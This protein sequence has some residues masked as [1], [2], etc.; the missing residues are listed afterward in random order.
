M[1]FSAFSAFAFSIPCLAAGVAASIGG[2]GY[3]TSRVGPDNADCERVTYNLSIE[4][5]NTIFDES[6]TSNINQTVLT[7]GLQDYVIG[8]IATSS[9]SNFSALYEVG[10]GKEKST[11][12]NT[13]SISGTL[14][15]PKG[16]ATN[17]DHVQY[18][19]HG[20]GFDSS[21]WDFSVS[22]EYSYVRASAAAGISTFRYDRL[23]TGLSEKPADSYNVVQA[24]TDLA[25]AQKLLTMLRNGN[26]GGQK[27]SKVVGVGHSYGSIQMQALS[28]TLPSALDGIILQ[29]FSANL[30]AG[31]LFWTSGAFSIAT[32]VF[33]DRFS[34][35]E[36]TNGYL[37]TLAPQTN[38]F[39]YFYYPWYTQAA[40][41]HT[42]ATEQPVSQA[43]LF[44]LT[45]IIQPA[46]SFKGPV[47]VVTGA[48]DFIFCL[49]NCYAIAADSGKESLLDYVQELY[50]VTSKFSTYIPADTGHSANQHISAPETYKEMLIF[51]KEVF[52]A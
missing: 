29:G 23:G 27:F 41:E 12:S 47:H 14:C 26:I 24:S 32:E 3:D 20:I 13:Y 37:V 34:K 15:I 45:T 8:F 44:T 7:R 25:I 11:V 40:F 46:T 5:N 2:A 16:G 30:T 1:H 4:S 10:G 28:A 17:K 9:A 49:G 22:E 42:R 18:L 39:N 36:L 31:P 52:S 33:P 38:Q 19:L 35:S 21:Y 50:P 48:K 43:V 51:V 6:Y